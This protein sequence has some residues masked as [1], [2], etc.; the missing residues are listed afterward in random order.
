MQ[1]QKQMVLFITVISIYSSAMEV[2]DIWFDLVCGSNK[3]T[4][5]KLDTLRYLS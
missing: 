3:Q 4:C 2:N 5:R 1:V